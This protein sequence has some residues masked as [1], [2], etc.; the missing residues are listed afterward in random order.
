MTKSIQVN[1]NK[2]AAHVEEFLIAEILICLCQHPET[3]TSH[4]GQHV[5]A[6]V[7]MLFD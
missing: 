7:H 1:D 3:L 4:L 5:T 2:R 6:R